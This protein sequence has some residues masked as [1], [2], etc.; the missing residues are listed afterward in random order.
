MVLN[1]NNYRAFAHKHHKRK[2]WVGRSDF[3]R[4][5]R[6]NEKIAEEIRKIHARPPTGNPRL[7]INLVITLFNTF[8]SDAAR[9]LLFFVTEKRF[10]PQIR[11]LLRITGFD[12]FDSETS[13]DDYCNHFYEILK[14]EISG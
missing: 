10:H 7:L 1:N 9:T 8:Q 4:D 11:S 5:V 3:L 14:K 12:V 2:D 13:Q 6:L